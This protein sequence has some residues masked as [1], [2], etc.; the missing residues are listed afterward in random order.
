MVFES[1]ARANEYVHVHNVR[2]FPQ[3]R[4]DSEIK[5]GIL[6]NGHGDLYFLC[7]IIVPMLSSLM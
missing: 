1:L 7:I 6:L 4:L 3:A 2:D 5:A